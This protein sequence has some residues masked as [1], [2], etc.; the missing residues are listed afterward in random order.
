VRL[1]PRVGLLVP[2]A[3]GWG[4]AAWYLWRTGVP[5]GLDLPDLE[6]S[7]YFR[8]GELDETA[9]YETFVRVDY[10]LA[11]VALLVVL[12]VYAW[13]GAR[14]TRESAA[15]RIGTGML[16]GMLGLAIVWLVQ[17]PFGLAALWWD[18][19]HDVSDQGYVE[20][21]L[22]D[23]W[24]LGSEFLFISLALLIVMGLAGPLGDRWWLFGAPAFVGLGLLFAF[25]FPILS[26][27]TLVALEDRAIAAEAR[28]LAAQ[29]GV[30]DVEVRVEEVSAYTDAPNAYAAGL[31]PSRKVVL[32]DTFLDGRFGDGEIRVVLAHEFAHHSRDHIWK[33]LGWYAL[34][35]VP[36][37][38]IVAR[39]T[40]RRGG[41]RA[42]E[43]VPLGLLVVVVLQFLAQPLANEFSRRQEAEADWVAL[44]STRDPESAR[45]LFEQFTHLTLQQPSPPTWS[46]LWL[47]THPTVMERIAMAEAWRARRDG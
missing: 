15:G 38:F 24:L 46:Y 37:A 44:E 3:A 5:S 4:A 2:L 23:W 22:G 16:L 8:P 19:R 40:R 1:L 34:F 33:W 35:A 32:W 25:L 30:S 20:W 18:R 36:G 6:P 43:A 9:D 41:M 10:M 26:S 42:P 29:Q 7:R 17:V 13:R 27:P 31:G 39:A 12:G 14:L 11:D 21:L 28:R 47:Y 45:R